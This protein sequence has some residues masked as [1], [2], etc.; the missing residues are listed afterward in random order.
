MRNLRDISYCLLFTESLSHHSKQ[1]HF[2]KLEGSLVQVLVCAASQHW[3]MVKKASL[4]IST[5]KDGEPCAAQ[6]QL[7]VART[8]LDT[9]CTVKRCSLC[10]NFQVLYFEFV[11]FSVKG[12]AIMTYM[13]LPNKYLR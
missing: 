12:L 9:Y 13:Y 5:S 8:F 4:C 7:P 2:R 11:H 6:L 10:D 3:V 1:L